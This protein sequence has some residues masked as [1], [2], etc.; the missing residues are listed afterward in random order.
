M[1][2]LSQISRYRTAVFVTLFLAAAFGM[3]AS[4]ARPATL[5]QARAYQWRNVTIKGG[6]F[7]SGVVFHLT[8]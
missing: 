1:S 8:E 3:S 5:A 6:G 4:A 2:I 7:V